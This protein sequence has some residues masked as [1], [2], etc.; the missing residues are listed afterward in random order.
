MPGINA[1][2]DRRRPY[3]AWLLRRLAGLVP[4]AAASAAVAA[5]LAAAFADEPWLLIPSLLLIGLV[6]GLL[7]GLVAAEILRCARCH[8]LGLAA[9]AQILRRR[10]RAAQPLIEAALPVL[11][12]LGIAPVIFPTVPETRPPFRPT[13]AGRRAAAAPPEEQRFTGI[14]EEKAPTGGSPRTARGT[15]DGSSLPF[16]ANAAPP[17]SATAPSVSPACPER[18][19][20]SRRAPRF[21]VSDAPA[22]AGTAPDGNAPASGGPP[23]AL[24][25]LTPAASRLVRGERLDPR[26]ADPVPFGLP[27]PWPEPV[28]LDR[29]GLPDERNPDARLPA[30]FRM[31]VLA[32]NPGRE[33][34]LTATRIGFDLPTAPQESVHLVLQGALRGIGEDLIE[35]RVDVLAWQHGVVAWTRRL[36]GWTRRAPFDLALSFGV[37]ADRFYRPFETRTILTVDDLE[38]VSPY[39]ALDVAMWQARSCGLL[40]HLGQT[41]PTNLTGD[42]ISLTEASLAVRYDLSAAVSV[43]A[44]M[45]AVHYALFDFERPLVFDEGRTA[46]QEFHVGPSVGVDVRF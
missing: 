9:E 45:D 22:A 2:V 36:A 14:S 16:R 5:S 12:V 34:A 29:L 1:M 41:I 32:L 6:A 33:E 37:S 10:L 43:H 7:L 25:A 30:E 42:A 19:S 17:A 40:F 28:T 26:R 23:D 46:L 31:D 13:E 35:N 4:A 3:R 20:A 11:A 8:A 38:R 24:I 21:S 18:A 44:G 39:A 27:D 15:G